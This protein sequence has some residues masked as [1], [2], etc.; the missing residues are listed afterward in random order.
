MRKILLFIFVSFFFTFSINAQ[1]SE[2]DRSATMQLLNT[3]K[4]AIGLSADDI[5]NLE[6]SSSF[7]NPI[8]GIRYVYLTQTYLGIPVFNQMQVLSFREGK[9]LSNFGSRLS[10]M[11]QRVNVKS[12]SPSITAEAALIAA[13]VD[14]K[15]STTE[16]TVT[17]TTSDNGRKVEFNKM[18]VSRENITAKLMWSPSDDGKGVK[19]AWQIYIIPTTSSD[20]WLVRIDATNRTTIGVDNLTVYCDWGNPDHTEKYGEVH[21]HNENV[22]IENISD[23]ITNDIQSDL[24]IAKRE[25]QLT[26]FLI[27]SATY[28]VIPFPFESPIH[29]PSPPS[30]ATVTDPW[31]AAPVKCDNFKMEYRNWREQIMIIPVAIMFG[32]IRIDTGNNTGTIAKSASSTT[33]LPNLTFNFVPDYTME[34]Q[35]IQTPFPI[36]NLISPIYSTGII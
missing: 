28:R 4:S 36:S 10:Q 27:T 3:N 33:P 34:P 12:A 25:K 11:E 2:N 8:N 19:L 7:L 20:Y 26:P 16:R 6:V 18:G 14:R 15:L 32:L 5:S 17:L 21:T 9:L 35:S 13:L 22:Q 29:M 31:L 23:N 24:T 1:V 30:S